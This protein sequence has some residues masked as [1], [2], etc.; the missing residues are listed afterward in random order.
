M[1]HATVEIIHDPLVD[2][3]AAKLSKS[4]HLREGRFALRFTGL[5][6]GTLSFNCSKDGVTISEGDSVAPPVV[7]MIGDRDLILSVLDGKK[8][9]RAQFIAGGFRIRGDLKYASDVALELG[10]IDQPL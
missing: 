2:R 5:N 9:G 1:A 10:I 6:Q 8:D 4:K 7:E 3:F